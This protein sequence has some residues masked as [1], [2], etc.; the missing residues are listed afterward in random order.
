MTIHLAYFQK[1]KFSEYDD[2]QNLF[3]QL[4]TPFFFSEK[5]QSVLCKYDR[6]TEK[7]LKK[8]W[9]E[10]PTNQLLNSYLKKKLQ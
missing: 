5:L 6:N 8:V 7:S 1:I 4:E 3:K 9:T 10:S 2:C